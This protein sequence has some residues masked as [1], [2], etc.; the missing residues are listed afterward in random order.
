MRDGEAESLGRL[1]IDDEIEFGRLLH[2]QIA[3]LRSA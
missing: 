3:R 1:E 2:R